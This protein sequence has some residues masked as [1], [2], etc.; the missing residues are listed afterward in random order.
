MFNSRKNKHILVHA[1]RLLSLRFEDI[2]NF[3]HPVFPPPGSSRSLAPGPMFSRSTP[4]PRGTGSLPANMPS[5]C[6]SSMMPIVMSTASS[7]WA[8]PRWEGGKTVIKF[9][10]KHRILVAQKWYANDLSVTVE[11]VFLRVFLRLVLYCLIAVKVV[12]LA[13]KEA[14]QYWWQ[15]QRPNTARQTT[16]SHWFPSA[17]AIPENLWG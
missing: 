6:P 14:F 5:P 15:S 1:K 17:P 2:P 7:A 4:P 3:S 11:Y 13:S 12:P 9:W 8:G 10:N 16:A